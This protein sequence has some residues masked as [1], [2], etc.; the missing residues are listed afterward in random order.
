MGGFFNRGLYYN[1]IKARIKRMISIGDT[2]GAEALCLQTLRELVGVVILTY[3]EIGHNENQSVTKP[4]VFEKQMQFIKE[5]RYPVLTYEDLVNGYDYNK[6]AIIITFD[7]ARAG[8]KDY[9]DSILREYNFPYTIFITPGYINNAGSFDPKEAFSNFLTWDEIGYLYEKGGVTLGSHSY[10]HRL[11]TELESEK[12]MRFEICDSKK[13]IEKHFGIKVTDF[14]YPYGRFTEN[15]EKMV[16]E[17]G[18]KTI[19]TILPGINTASTSAFR[20]RRSVVLSMFSEKDFIKIINPEQ[21]RNEF[22]EILQELR[23]KN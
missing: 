3:H 17:E 19:S 8:V 6:M 13:E 12:D 2:I 14:A 18:Y 9:A 23:D 11:M 21:I 1:Q 5:Y 4:S 10:T 22:I 20:L 7:D 15:I 16:V